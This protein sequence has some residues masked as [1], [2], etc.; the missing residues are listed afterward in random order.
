MGLLVVTHDRQR[1]GR[2]HVPARRDIWRW[3]LWRYAEYELD[4]ANIGREAGAS[5]H[6]GDPSAGRPRF[7]APGECRGAALYLISIKAGQSKSRMN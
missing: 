1:I 4:L 3:S 5:T 6:K 7:Q 2:R